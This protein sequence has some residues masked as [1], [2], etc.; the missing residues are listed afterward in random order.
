MYYKPR[1]KWKMQIVVRSC[2]I[3]LW[4]KCYY[5]IIYIF[6]VLGFVIQ[7]F[8]IWLARTNLGQMFLKNN[9]KIFFVLVLSYV[10]P[11]FVLTNQKQNTLYYKIKINFWKSEC[12]LTQGILNNISNI[13]LKPNRSRVRFPLKFSIESA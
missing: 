4:K 6:L 8:C 10:C 11:T 13:L 3:S 1:T 2:K 7:I 9:K 5:K 12:K